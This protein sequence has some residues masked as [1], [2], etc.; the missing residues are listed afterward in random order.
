MTFIAIFIHFI[1]ILLLTFYFNILKLNFRSVPALKC[2]DKSRWAAAVAGTGAA[3]PAS[4]AAVI[5]KSSGKQYF[6][7]RPG[8]PRQ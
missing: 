6:F 7:I 1:R 2:E 5:C 8:D 3:A 4:V